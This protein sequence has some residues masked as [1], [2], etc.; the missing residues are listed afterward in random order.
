MDEIDCDKDE[1]RARK[2]VRLRAHSYDDGIYFV[3]SC[4]AEKKHYFGY[5]ADGV[6]HLND[7]GKYL[8]KILSEL[9]NHCNYAD[10]P[11]WVVMPNHFHAII[12]IRPV[13]AGHARLGCGDCGPNWKR[14]GLPTV[15]ASIKSAVS[16][17]AHSTGKQFGWQR[18]YYDH[19]IRNTLK[20]NEIDNYIRTNPQRWD[21][22]CYNI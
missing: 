2:S 19:I 21:K 15:M 10:V 20:A 11:L 9:N 7:V 4:T 22:D 1:L 17:Y 14:Y 5:V 8:D 18:S 13:G 12:V 6:M 3:T 16:K